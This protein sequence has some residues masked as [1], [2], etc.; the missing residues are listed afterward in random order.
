MDQ[1]IA[2]LVFSPSASIAEIARKHNVNRN[3]L[4]SGY[5]YGSTRL[6]DSRGSPLLDDDEEYTIV[7]EIGRHCQAFGPPPLD[8]IT[9]MVE[10]ICGKAIPENWLARFLRC[11]K[12][13]F[14]DWMATPL[15]TGES[16][17]DSD[18]L[19]TAQPVPEARTEPQ[20]EVHPVQQKRKRHSQS[21]ALDEAHSEVDSESASEQRSPPGG[22]AIRQSA[23][24]REQRA[25]R[26]RESRKRRT[27]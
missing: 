22:R 10:S 20:S 4:S 9:D 16:S 27:S 6:T 13:V 8:L 11:Y 15:Y 12:H 14:R 2:D 5:R 25:L 3:A 19:G 18:N 23:R 17:S 21:T 24:L 7:K 1:A 26:K